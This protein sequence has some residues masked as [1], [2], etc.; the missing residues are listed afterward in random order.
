MQINKAWFLLFFLSW[1]CFPQ[2]GE[3]LPLKIVLKQISDSNN[4]KFTYLDE[5]LAVYTLASPDAGL[6]LNVKLDYIR[7]NTKLRIEMITAGYYSVYNDQKMDKALCGYII[8]TE[9]GDGVENAIIRVSGLQ[10]VMTD[11]NGYFALPELTPNTITIRHMGY[12]EKTISPQDLYV[13]DCPKINMVPVVTALAEVVTQ[14]YLTT[15]ISKIETGE[16]VVKPSKFGIL[17]GLIEADVLQTMQQIP[18]IASLDETVSN[19]NVR[20]GTHDQNLFLWNNIRMFQTAHFFGLI[21]AFNPLP[22]TRIVISKNGSSA[23]LGESVSSTAAISSDITANKNHVIAADMIAGSFLSHIKLSRNSSLQVSGRRTFSDFVASPTFTSY[24]DRI[25]QNTT[26]TDL[27]QNQEVQVKS[28]ERFYFY[29]FSLQYRLK[30][31]ERNALSVDLIGIDNNLNVFQESPVLNKTSTLAQQNFGAGLQWKHQW[32]GSHT[33]EV[34]GFTSWYDLQS[35]STSVMTNQF[36]AQRNTVFDKNVTVRHNYTFSKN[37]YVSAGYQF[38][39]VSIVNSDAINDPAF[40]RYEKEVSLSHALIT[41]AVYDP[42]NGKT[43]IRAGLRGNYFQKYR[44]LLIEPRLTISHSVTPVLKM[45]IMGELKS[46]TLSQLIDQQQDFL[47]IEK[48]R[49]TLA[50]ESDVPIQKSAQLSLGMTYNNDGWLVGL[51]NFYKKVNGITSDGQGFQNQFEFENAT[52]NYSVIGTEVL[53]Q[54]TF[55]RFYSWISYSFNDN[56]YHFN[57]FTPPGFS[58]NF[59]TSHEVSW[60]AIYEWNQLRIAFGAKWHTGRPVTTPAEFR[61]DADNPANSIIIY[62]APN[63]TLLDDYLQVNFS[64]SKAWS[65]G[66]RSVVKVSGAVLNLLDCENVIG[67]FYRVNRNKNAVES[68]STYALGF[69]PN[70]SVKV[71]F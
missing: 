61:I 51:D 26:I 8:D 53:L 55:G 7:R 66:K 14:H 1:Y 39:A 20:G 9:T 33:S 6:P 32:N 10:D 62:N 43:F 5:E 25:F 27:S 24:Q 50:D 46:Q 2:T 67:R 47:G 31:D 63:N 48:R 35:G 36:T 30:A 28:D 42:E 64:A 17:P 37:G 60:A 15:G 21:S 54:K 16:L 23:F 40:S 71:L 22:A 18:G 34:N 3:K 57:E 70:M 41:E 11:T 69:T 52:G 68:V 58:N 13:S 45:E 44:S 59:A 56:Q 38:D 65:I 19:V 4:V 12:A 29:D 49:W